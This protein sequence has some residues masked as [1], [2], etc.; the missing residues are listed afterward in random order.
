MTLIFS[1]RP[2]GLKSFSQIW[3]SYS[4]M[5]RFDSL[6]KR[7]FLIIDS[8]M[9]VFSSHSLFSGN[10]RESQFF[11]FIFKIDVSRGIIALLSLIRPSNVSGII[12]FVVINS[13]QRIPMR[14]LANV[15]KEASK[16]FKPWLKYLN[17]SCPIQTIFFAFRI[18]ASLFHV[19][20]RRVCSVMTI[21][22][23]E[24]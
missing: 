22:F 3:L 19:Y 11:A 18:I 7:H 4:F 24:I 5:N 16:G 6:L 15:P 13:I 2:Q 8:S 23:H 9:K 1:F 14:P 21:K 17:A 20:P 10:F 12:A